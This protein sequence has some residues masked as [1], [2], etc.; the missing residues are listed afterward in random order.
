MNAMLI[1][2]R[3]SNFY[4]PSRI[5]VK[6]LNAAGTMKNIT[7]LAL[8]AYSK[9][10]WIWNRHDLGDL[11]TVFLEC[12]TQMT[13]RLKHHLCFMNCKAE[14][15][16]KTIWI[17]KNVVDNFK[18]SYL[19]GKNLSEMTL[20]MLGTPLQYCLRLVSCIYCVIIV[21]FSKVLS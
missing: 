14:L 11:G 15:N 5:N 19:N 7:T 1:L 16:S 18:E 9:H 17:S 8:W 20:S 6:W 10:S 2:Q 3:S 13:P 21:I 4:S 12:L